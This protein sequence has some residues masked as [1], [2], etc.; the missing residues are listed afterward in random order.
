M[1]IKSHILTEFA[2]L[3]LNDICAGVVMNGISD[4]IIFNKDR[5][6]IHLLPADDRTMEKER[7]KNMVIKGSG[8][9]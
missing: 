1:Q 5:T 3:F 9:K 2:Q 6:S 8:D 4:D 7:S